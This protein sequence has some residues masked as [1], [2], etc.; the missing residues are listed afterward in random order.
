MSEFMHL[1]DGYKLDHRR[2][3]PAG[4]QFVYSNFTARSSRIEG[5]TH[6]IFLGLQAFLYRYLMDEA[7]R[8]FFGKPKELV[9]QSYKD[10]L[11]GYFGPDAAAD[12]GVEHIA[13]LHDLGYIPLRFCALPE[14][15]AVPLGV[16]M[17]TIENTLPE[18]FWVTNYFETLISSAIWL[19]CTSATTAARYRKV[20]DKYAIETTGSTAGVQ[21]QGH[22]FSFRGM[23]SPEAAAMSGLGHLL[24]FTGTDSLPSIDFAKNYYAAEGLVGGSVPAT[25]HSVMCAG[26]QGDELETYDRIIGLYPKGIVSIVS[27][28]WDLWKV[29]EVILPKLKDKIMARDGKVVI[30]PDSGDPV[31]ILCGDP[32][33]DWLLPAHHGVID[34]LWA[35]FGGTV[36]EQ[37]YRVLDSHIGAIYGDS[38]TV[39]RAEEICQRLK[40]KGYASTNVVFGIGSYTYNYTTRDVHSFAIKATWTQRNDIPRM[41][42]KDPVTGSG[43]KSASGRLWVNRTE[44]GELELI[45]GFYTKGM[46]GGELKPVWENGK[47]LSD[48]TLYEMRERAEESLAR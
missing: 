45:D 16:P 35:Q 44:T 34:L 25:E 31:K 1:T 2:Q 46:D 27:D 47:F 11:T 30:R 14:G 17:F 8:N 24:F 5:Q 6:V 21:W 23:A 29:I 39:E 7:N 36:N 18:F 12:I 26:G 40:A 3:Y 19:A 15:T 10:M 20:L 38:I 48:L 33:E 43:K 37:G 41:M 32:E 4:T 13:A 28:T 9:L 22:D 42:Q